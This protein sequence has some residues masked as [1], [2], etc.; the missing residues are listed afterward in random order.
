MNINP[1]FSEAASRNYVQNADAARAQSA[2][3]PNDAAKDARATSRVDSVVLSANARSVA[4]AREAVK[5][6]PDV[7]EEKVSE[8]RQRVLDGTYHVPA[9]VLAGKLLS[10]ADG[11]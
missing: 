8:I 10:Q 5:S 2:E 6:S 11:I 3:R 9:K 4:A 7:R 1:L